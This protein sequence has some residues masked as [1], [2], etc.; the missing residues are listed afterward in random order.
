MTH[1]TLFG[2]NHTTEP[3][4]LVAKFANI[5]SEMVSQNQQNELES[6]S[7]SKLD[8][9]ESDVEIVETKTIS[10]DKPVIVTQEPK[11]D[12]DFSMGVILG[13]VIGIAIGIACLFI[14]R[15]KTT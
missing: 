8:L 12:S 14:I 13:L 2:G 10:E 9:K 1:S 15:Q 6:E 5:S 3:I 4:T 7:S 11:F